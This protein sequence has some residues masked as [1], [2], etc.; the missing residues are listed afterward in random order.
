MS[1]ECPDFQTFMEGVKKRNPGQDEFVQAVHEVS[2]DIFDWIQD[3]REYHE[4]EILRRIAEPDRIVSFRVCWEDDDHNIRVERGWRV[5]NNNAIGPYKG[6]LRFHPSVT[7]SVLKF[8]AFEQTFKNSLTGLP[9]GGG[10]GGANFNP[11]GKSDAEVMRFCQ[12][13]MTE[14][15]RHI[16]P[17]V[18]VPAGDIG[19]GSREIGYLFGQYK[20]IT[21]RWEGVLTGKANEY[22]G[23]PMRVEATGYGAVHFLDH[24]LKRRDE[25]IEGKRIV[26]SGSGNVALHAAEKAIALG[27]KVVSL[28]DSDGVIHVK[29]GIGAEQLEWIKQLKIEERGR[30]SEVADKYDGVEFHEDGEPW[31]IDADIAMPCATQNEIGP[32]EA[33]TLVDNGV[34]AV[35]EG[36]NMPTT[37]DAVEV[38][39]DAKLLFAPGKAAN[40]GGVAVSGLEM[41]QNAERVSWQREKLEDMLADLM[42]D[43]HGKCVEHGEC[44]D[45]YIDYAKGANIA[46]FRK[47]A[48]AMLA[49]GV[50]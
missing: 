23:S 26:I 22:G 15:Y 4:A 10:K 2:R 13:F 41:S 3:K 31:G 27:G 38:L 18:D 48:D 35:V 50:M 8:L 32:D 9:M 44:S 47:V 21:N 28:S 40:A 33:K 17:D 12:S 39:R 20:R 49:F 46:G 36:A 1:A 7:E 43:I 11:K 16:G 34:M 5:Q 29:D 14:L 24:M 6:G 42:E 19:V 45:G 25:E 37:N 30:I